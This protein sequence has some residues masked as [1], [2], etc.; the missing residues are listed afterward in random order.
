MLMTWEQSLELG[1]PEMD[2]EHKKLVAHAN[3]LF[4]AIKNK[5]SD[6]EIIDLLKFLARYTTEHFDHEERFQK[7]IQYPD[8]KA[9]HVIHEEFKKTVRDMLKEVEENGLTA[10][11]KIDIN[12]LT[13]RWLQNHIGVDDRKI[14]RYYLANC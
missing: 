6:R 13:I 14:A 10:K 9:H 7:K 12:T 3:K 2:R 11:M 1:V 4:E 5:G 8:L